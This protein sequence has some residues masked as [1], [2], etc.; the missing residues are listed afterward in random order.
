MELTPREREI[1]RLVVHSFIAT[2]GPVGSRFLAREYPLGLSPASIRNTMSDLEEYGYLDHPYTSAGRIPT[3]LGYRTFVDELMEA[4]TLSPLEKQV[5]RQEIERLMGDPDGVLRESS[6]ILGKLSSL[7]GLVLSP[8]LDSGVLERLELVPLSSSRIMF[9]LS[10]RG[11]LVKTIILEIETSFTRRDLD[12]I[13]SILNERL[14]GLTLEDIRETYAERVADI[15]DES[16]GIVRLILHRAPT[17]FADASGGRR[18]EFAGTQNMMRQPEFQE[19]NELHRMIEMLED[20]DFVVQLLEESAHESDLEPGAVR[21]SI[22][23]EHANEKA[24]RVSVIS[25]R[26]RMGDTLGTIGVIGPM[27]MDYGRVVAVVESM[28]RLLSG[29]NQKN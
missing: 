12:R 19:P 18:L 8:R 20:S 24:E 7:L 21:V 17:L 27:R 1:L 23:R 10:V 9:V 16:S 29:P 2:A 26:Y 22:G 3:E 11:S 13:V 28:A 25:A 6:R 15:A 14:A 4:P 5:L